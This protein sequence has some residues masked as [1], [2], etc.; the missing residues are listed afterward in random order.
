MHHPGKLPFHLLYPTDFLWKQWKNYMQECLWHVTNTRWIL[1]V[2][3]QPP[4]NQGS[5]LALQQ[6]VRLNLLKLYIETVQKKAICYVLQAISG[7][8]IWVYNCWNVKSKYI[9]RAL[10]YNLIWEVM[11]IFLNDS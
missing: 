10:A 9:W 6:L 11:I 1:W 7:R 3:I 8:P 4:P 5:L 2:V